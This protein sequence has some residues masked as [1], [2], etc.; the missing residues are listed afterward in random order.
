MSTFFYLNYGE[1]GSYMFNVRDKEACSWVYQQND[2]QKHLCLLT[3]TQIY[4]HLQDLYS[5]AH[6]DKEEKNVSLV[7]RPCSRVHCWNRRVAPKAYAFSAEFQF[8]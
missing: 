3:L 5:C 8:I 4:T 1:S 6:T 2:S 7:K